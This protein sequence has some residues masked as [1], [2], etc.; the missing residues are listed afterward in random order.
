MKLKMEYMGLKN[1]K[2]KLN[3]KI[4][5]TKQKNTHMIFNNKKQ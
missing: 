1:G 3:D 4:L 5:N 2:T